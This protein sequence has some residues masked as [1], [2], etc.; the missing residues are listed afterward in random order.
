MIKR[1][2]LGELKAHLGQ[3]EMSFLI[4][5][6]QAGK[7]TLMLILKE[8]LEKK[9]QKTLFLNFDIE[10][11]RQ[12]FASQ[13]S[14][15][16]KIELEIGKSKAYIF[17]DEI[18]RKENAG[19]FLKGIYDMQLPYKFIVSGSGSVELKEQIHESLVGRKRIFKLSTL[20]F[21]EFINFKTNYRYENKL[22]DFLNL[23][24]EKSREILEEYLNFGGYPRV[25]LAENLPEKQKIID[26]IYQSYLEKD[27]FYLLNIKK[28]ENFGN[29]VKLLAG[30]IGNLVNLSELSATLGLSVK[31]VKDYLWYLEKT[32]I[33]QKVNPYFQNLRKEIT[34]SPVF[35]FSD[36]GLRNYSVEALGGVQNQKDIGFVFEN[37]VLNLL[38]QKI[39]TSSRKINFW[40]TKDGAEVDFIIS[41]S[42]SIVPVEVKYKSFKEPKITRSL[43]SFIKKYSPD[44]AF[45]VNLNLNKNLVLNKTKIIF[46]SYSNFLELEV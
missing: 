39:Q 36:L 19:L 29:L 8:Y 15:V 42:K 10:R 25:V 6:R 35:Y 32:F 16:Q 17:L 21:E 1:T 43:K 33:I 30:Q 27:I 5:P 13:A 26:E 24:Q 14:L 45:V 37:F 4:G 44:K 41:K 38:K 31:T 18:Q 28:T 11:D 34:K 2:I 3:K 20:S 46:I 9:G 12:F 7:T 23:D 40:R 22:L